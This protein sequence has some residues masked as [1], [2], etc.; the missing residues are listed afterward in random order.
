MTDANT[1]VRRSPGRNDVKGCRKCRQAGDRRRRNG[2]PALGTDPGLCGKKRHPMTPEN[3][4]TRKHP[5]GRESRVC[6]ACERAT[7]LRRNTGRAA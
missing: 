2:G 4:R 5:D 7:R 3:T 1:Y 6:K